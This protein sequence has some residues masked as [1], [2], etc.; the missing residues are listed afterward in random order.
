M[1]QQVKM[2]VSEV[3]KEMLEYKFEYFGDS[4]LSPTPENKVFSYYSGTDEQKFDVL[5][6]MDELK[7]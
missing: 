6:L 1:I 5:Y 2:Y 3:F 4:P 7:E